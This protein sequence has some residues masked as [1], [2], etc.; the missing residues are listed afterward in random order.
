M[1]VSLLHCH[2]RYCKL[3]FQ[4]FPCGTVSSK[5]C[6][7]LKVLQSSYSKL[8]KNSRTLIDNHEPMY[9]SSPCKMKSAATHKFFV[10]SF[11]VILF[12]SIS[13][14]QSSISPKIKSLAQKQKAHM[15]KSG[16]LLDFI[17]SRKKWARTPFSLQAFQLKGCQENSPNWLLK[18]A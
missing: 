2:E 6:A 13:Q 9:H 16:D 15:W 1:D 17:F 12:V 4:V 5:I 3:F 11:F 18:T 10:S 7:C 14:L 8:L